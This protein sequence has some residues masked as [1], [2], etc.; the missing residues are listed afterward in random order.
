MVVFEAKAPVSASTAVLC[1]A[2]TA[3]SVVETATSVTDTAMSVMDTA[4]SVADT[5][6]SVVDTAMSVA[7]TAVSVVDTVVSVMD[8]AMFVMETVVSAPHS[9][10]SRHCRI[11]D[12]GVGSGLRA[13]LGSPVSVSRLLLFPS[14]L[15]GV[16]GRGRQGRAVG[17][18]ALPD[19]AADYFA[20]MQ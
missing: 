16:H 15:C 3:T 11:T 1:P 14:P 2:D 5:A 13:C 8:T 6:M 20:P 12:R 4:T 18:G 19:W 10:A 17:A 7:D 9:P